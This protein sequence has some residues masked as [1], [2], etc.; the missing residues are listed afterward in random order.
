V[1]RYKV[2][3]LGTLGGAGSA[4]YGINN[5]TQ[6]VGE[7]LYSN[8]ANNEH[9]FLWSGGNMI[10]L[11]TLGGPNSVATASDIQGKVVGAS[12]IA[13]KRHAFMYEN[14]IMTDMNPLLSSSHSAATDI[15]AKGQIVGGAVFDISGQDELMHAFL[16][17]TTSGKVKDL[18]TLPGR[19]RSIAMAVNDNGQVVGG[20][21]HAGVADGHPFLYDKG[22]MID[23]TPN[24]L[25]TA[26]A[27]NNLGQVVGASTPQGA[28]IYHNGQLKYIN[29]S[30]LPYGINDSGQVVGSLGP[31]AG[32][33]MWSEQQGFIDLNTLLPSNSGWELNGADAINEQ[34]EIV[35]VG[36]FM[37]DAHAYLLTQS[38][39]S[40]WPIPRID[41]EMSVKI[42]F[43][44]TKD[45]GG[46]VLKPGGT[47]GPIDPWGP[48]R[49]AFSAH[50]KEMLASAMLVGI[51][52]LIDSAEVRGQLE[53]IATKLVSQMAQKI[54]R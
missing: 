30:G 20:S 33:W 43:G 42:L 37:G 23:L 18:G 40:Q 12:D 16:F 9:A 8:A 51:A 27:L 15:N 25:G 48:L 39:E 7:S 41:E 17:D 4:A 45:G 3:D 52:S 22:K 11:G 13:G 29:V 1:A 36:Q 44:V 24:S 10:D 53:E 34:G 21:R 32:A 6:I 2:I 35:G 54:K 31:G 26:W 46:R 47:P 14:G 38:K 28:F 49:E 19:Q 5:N 50:S